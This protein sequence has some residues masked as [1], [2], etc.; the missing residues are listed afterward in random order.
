MGKSTRSLTEGK[1][2]THTDMTTKAAAAGRQ[3]EQAEPVGPTGHR[4]MEPSHSRAAHVWR[5]G[6]SH[7]TVSAAFAALP[8][9]PSGKSKKKSR[10]GYTHPWTGPY[11]GPWIRPSQETRKRSLSLSETHHCPSPKVLSRRISDQSCSSCLALATPY[12][13]Y[14]PAAAESSRGAT[15]A[16][17]YIHGDRVE[18]GIS[19]TNPTP[20]VIR[21]F[22]LSLARHDMPQNHQTTWRCQ[23][24]AVR[25]SPIKEIFHVTLRCPVLLCTNSEPPASN[26]VNTNSSSPGSSS[27]TRSRQPLSLHR[28]PLILCVTLP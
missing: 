3:E 17:P 12:T 8:L 15:F 9:S 18:A 23:P 4:R 22:T 6:A 5:C 2:G 20:P 28:I 25:R 19:Y 7:L 16:V 10:R 26:M 27:A 21:M 1:E 11:G 24:A 13:P 14:L